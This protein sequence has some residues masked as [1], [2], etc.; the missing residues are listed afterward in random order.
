MATLE[1]IILLFVAV[2]ISAVLERVIPRVSLPLIQITLGLVIAVL[3]LNPADVSL[4]PEFFLVLFIAPLLFHDAKESDK[5]ALW[6]NRRAILSLAVGLVI[7]I[8]LAIG[9]TVNLL[10]PSI[11]LAAALALGA[12]L[13]PTDAVA[14]ASLSSVAKL[15]R[16]E[17]ALLSGESLLNDASGVVAFQF[18]IAATTTGTFSVLES[19]GSF[20]VLFT[21]GLIFGLTAG[22]IA[23][24]LQDILRKA[25]LD[26]TTF[27]VM[28][29]VA[30]P[31]VIYVASEAL[32]VSG[33]I[34]VVAAGLIM[35]SVEDRE[36]SPSASRLSIVNSSV[37]GVLSFGLNGIVF[38]MLGMEL[39]NAFQGTWDDVTIGNQTV[40]GYVL[41][42]T[43]I[44]IAVRF[45]WV[46]V[47]NYFVPSL[48][49]RLRS[50]LIT[51]IGG[52]KGA[53]T[54]SIIFSI[55]YVISNGG[56]FPQRHLIIFLA[57]GV[58]LCTL[59]I[60]NFLLPLLAPKDEDE[61]SNAAEKEVNA[62]I[63]ILRRVIERLSA[64][65]SEVSMQ[66]TAAVI[67]SYNRR[68]ERI[69]NAA[70]LESESTTALRIDV[71]EHEQSHLFELIEAGDVEEFQAYRYLRR[72]SKMRTYLMHRDE[73]P[74][75]LHRLH[76]L[77][78][79]IVSYLRTGRQRVHQSED[80]AAALDVQAR[81]QA[82][83]IRYLHTLMQNEE[84]SY[85]TEVIANVLLTYQNAY[86]ATQQ[87]RPSITQYTSVSD[88]I[89]TVERMAYRFELD[90]IQDALEAG[91][92]D[93]K[94]AKNLNESVYLMMVDLE[95]NL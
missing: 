10:E 17:R 21:G 92:I 72:L 88:R 35:S 23:Q 94:C 79:L 95:M 84:S 78:S 55:P 6:K 73:S 5:L 77:Y 1:L 70:D 71:I 7:V 8:M 16:T 31:F 60:A 45:I 49:E 62:R 65:R 30:L 13:G 85:P 91:E 80:G 46:A 56:G 68:I 50:T 57:S 39:S 90:E 33:I 83:A 47:M 37:W 63:D 44:L 28:F 52:P 11:P 38:T 48:K 4:N 67:N 87:S 25:G 51:T 66:A 76:H 74:F 36:V 69:Q 26:S 59:L 32:G 61:T 58:I 42:I 89:E 34:S 29:D 12:A 3:S 75:D 9:F 19:A 40:I 18:A 24:W 53:V 93:R 2:L 27:H 20:V 86:R 81:S 43:F 64:A 15:S 41:A 82:E 54:L 14:V 22:W